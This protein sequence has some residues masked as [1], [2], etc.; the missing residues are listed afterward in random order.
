M[1]GVRKPISVAILLNLSR[2]RRIIMEDVNGSIV[3][4][5]WAGC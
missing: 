4:E 5:R 2:K 1:P 3:R